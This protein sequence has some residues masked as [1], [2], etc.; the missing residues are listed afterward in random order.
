MAL[1]APLPQL[2]SAG[3]LLSRGQIIPPRGNGQKQKQAAVK[4]ASAVGKSGKSGCELDICCLCCMLFQ[5]LQ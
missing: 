5:M 4:G 2:R 1:Q 3:P